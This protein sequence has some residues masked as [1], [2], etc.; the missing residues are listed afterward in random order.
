MDTDPSAVYMK[1]RLQF[2]T[3]ELLLYGLGGVCSDRT[4]VALTELV[5]SDIETGA[6]IP[7]NPNH[8]RGNEYEHPDHGG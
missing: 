7:S 4:E 3:I 8:D 5:N 2:A 1:S 6:E